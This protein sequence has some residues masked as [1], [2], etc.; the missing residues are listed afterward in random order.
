MFTEVYWHH[1]ARAITAMLKRVLLEFLGD[2]DPSVDTS[3]FD[4]YEDGGI[5]KSILGENIWTANPYY[6]TDDESLWF[7]RNYAHSRGKEVAFQLLSAIINGRFYK[8]LR[9]D[10]IYKRIITFPYLSKDDPESSKVTDMVAKIKLRIYSK[11]WKN[12]TNGVV[13]NIRERTGIK[14]LEEHH[15]I[16]DVAKKE[17]KFD[18]QILYPKWDIYKDIKDASPIIRQLMFLFEKDANRHVRIFCHPKYWEQL[19]K[20]RNDIKEA[21][22]SY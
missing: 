6:Y 10:G 7:L 1:A 9:E 14:D 22:Q 20:R 3:I 11:D 19:S 12:F 13:S 2:A 16:F 4:G 5:N 8:N 21:I 18:F 17:E 15:L